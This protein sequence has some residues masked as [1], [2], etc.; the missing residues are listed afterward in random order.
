MLQQSAIDQFRGQLRGEL[1]RPVDEIVEI[2]HHHRIHVRAQAQSRD[3]MRLERIIL[4]LADKRL[5][6]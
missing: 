1:I 3:E 4:P 6:C 2:R 5:E